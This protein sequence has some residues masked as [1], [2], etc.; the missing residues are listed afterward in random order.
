ML[1]ST[2]AAEI[3]AHA[4]G[5]ECEAGTP[6]GGAACG[7]D[8]GAAVRSSGAHS[9]Y[10]NIAGVWRYCGDNVA[11]IVRTGSAVPHAFDP[12]DGLEFTSDG[13]F[14]FLDE[15]AEGELTRRLGLDD[16]GTVEAPLNEPESFVQLDFDNGTSLEVR[17]I[18]SAC[19]ELMR[20]VLVRAYAPEVEYS[21]E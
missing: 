10:R 1:T 6:T 18:R 8:F 9:L 19:P 3:E 21:R 14:Y 16:T 5:S 2:E 15:T 4:V 17:V 13:T 12:H 11:D 20:L 7:L